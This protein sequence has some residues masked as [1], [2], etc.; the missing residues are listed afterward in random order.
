MWL[1]FPSFWVLLGDNYDLFHSVAIFTTAAV[2]GIGLL[3]IM[4]CKIRLCSASNFMTVL[5]WSV[6]TVLLFLPAMHERYAY[7][8]DI[9][10]VLYMFLDKSAWGYTAASVLCS[11]ATYGNYLC[12]N[13]TNLKGLSLVFTAAYLHFTARRL[14]ECGRDETIL[15]AVPM[16]H[17]ENP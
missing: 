6:W 1:N 10:L 17:E 5:V 3:W 2:L 12:G 13:G 14:L 8:L 7:S 4:R 9:F 15:K 11:F 16:N